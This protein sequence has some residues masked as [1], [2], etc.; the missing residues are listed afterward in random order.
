MAS[1]TKRIKHKS[2]RKS[3]SKRNYK[4]GA[5][6]SVKKQKVIEMKVPLFLQEIDVHDLREDEGYYF[7]IGKDMYY[8][9][10]KGNRRFTNTYNMMPGPKNT[11]DEPYNGLVEAK[12]KI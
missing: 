6:Q 9:T 5:N 7:D 3:R 4:G 10:Y 8:G 11:Y 2:K 12:N 1:N